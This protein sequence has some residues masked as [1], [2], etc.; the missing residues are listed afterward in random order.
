[1]KSV[2]HTLKHARN[3]EDALSKLTPIK[4]KSPMK[5]LSSME[6]PPSIIG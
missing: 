5:V 1:M 6:R 4:P 2:I 3:A